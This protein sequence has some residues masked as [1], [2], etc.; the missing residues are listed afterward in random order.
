MRTI[1]SLKTSIIFLLCFI[2][3][4]SF[5]QNPFITTWEIQSNSLAIEVDPNLEYNYDVDWESDGI[6]DDIG[7]TEEISHEYAEPGIFSISIRGEFPRFNHSGDLLG[8]LISVDQWGDIKWNRFDRAFN[9]AENMQL[10]AT[11]SPDLSEVTNVRFMF[12]GCHVMNADLSD[13]DM[14]NIERIGYM[15]WRCFAFNGDVTTWNVG[16]ANNMENMFDGCHS[17]NQDISE[18]DVS[19]STTMYNMFQNCYSFDQELNDWDVSRVIDTRSM[20]QNCKVFNRDLPNWDVSKVDRSW[21]MFFG[22]SRFNG[23]ISQWD[24]SGMT[25]M[26][27]MFEGCSDF[28]GDL[29][30][31]DVSN[32]QRF[33]NMFSGCRVFTGDLSSWDVSSATHMSSM[34]N[35]CTLFNSDISGWDVSKVWWMDN[36]FYG[37]T[38]FNADIS[39]WNPIPKYASGMFIDAS[40]FNQNLGSW[41]FTD[42][43]DLRL[44]LQG[45]GLDCNNYASLLQN[46]T[47]NPN[48]P[49]DMLV[50]VDDLSYDFNGK[51]YRDSLIDRGWSFFGDRLASCDPTEQNFIST[52][53]TDTQGASCDSCIIITTRDD[54]VYNYDIDWNNDG[55]FDSIGVKGDVEHKFGSSGSFQIAIRGQFPAIYFNNEGDKEKIQSIDQW[56]AIEWESMNSAFHGCTN[57]SNEANDLPNLQSVTDLSYM[58][59]DAHS[60]NLDMGQWD[61]SQVT[62]MTA[63]LDTSGIDCKNYS[64]TLLG[65]ATNPLSPINITLGS[66]GLMYDFNSMVNRDSLLQKNWFITGDEASDCT[67]IPRPFVT[68]WQ[69]NNPGASCNSC[70]TIPTVDGVTYS[71]D[72]DWENDGIYDEFGVNRSIV[73]DYGTPGTYTVAI[74]GAFPQISFY[75]TAGSLASKDDLEKIININQWGDMQWESMDRAFLRCVN[76]KV[77]AT[78]I[79]DLSKV[80]SMVSMF[81]FCPEFDADVSQ[82]DVSNVLNLS[83]LFSRCFKFNSD[84]SLWDVSNVYNMGGLFGYCSEFDQNLDTWNVRGVDNMNGMFSKCENFNG[85]IDNWDVSN[86][87]AMELM[88]YGC[89]I[90]NRDIS[91]W[92]VSN[93]SNMRGLFLDCVNFNIDLKDWD[94]GSVGNM[95]NMFEGCENFNQALDQWDVSGVGGMREMFRGCKSFNSNL[96]SWDVSNVINMLE[97]FYDC[98]S[99]NGDISD[100]DV[101]KVR[102]FE[103][104]FRNCSLFNGELSAWDVSANFRPTNFMFAG[105]GDFNSNINNWDMSAVTAMEG[106][107]QGCSQFSSDLSSWDVSKANSMNRMFQDCI[108]FDSDLEEWNVSNVEDMAYMFQ[109]CK[110]FNGDVIGWDVS[111]VTDMDFM[112]DS[113]YLFNQDIGEWDVSAVSRMRWMFSNARSF[114]QNIGEWDVSMVY[115]MRFMFSNARSF[116]QDIGNWNLNSINYLF[117]FLDYSG[118]GCENYG[119]TLEGW[120]SSETTP[121]NII[122]GVRDVQYNASGEAYRDMLIEGGWTF[123]GDIK[124]DCTVSLFE[125]ELNFSIYPNPTSNVINIDSDINVNLIITDITG[126]RLIESINAN[127]IDLSEL[128]NGIYF[129]EIMSDFQNLI[130]IEKIIKI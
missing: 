66:A 39:S 12:S 9:G 101:G 102:Y 96:N 64:A 20:F 60:M 65:W 104:M 41:D 28:N 10:L 86:V 58:F 21:N 98:T 51:E 62:D 128:A 13:W 111:S 61:I 11:D 63:M 114:D 1:I 47:Q 75:G 57:L 54:L 40:S 44:F 77:D 90:F 89:S 88:F 48:L 92:D 72:V 99:F 31:W 38:N 122:V 91:D 52:W 3:Q 126:Q 78:D 67:Y 22:C 76:L 81:G 27:G 30:D 14:S 80:R 120:S 123:E 4:L 36:M 100:W 71:Y 109:N 107:F 17:F 117:E 49:N 6:Y 32:N 18:W 26:L 119:K 125:N 106:M 103:S 129:L 43:E 33:Y 94:V 95:S 19:R 25:S 121:N 7:V 24:V 127:R 55:I 85:N 37:A 16:R 82:W 130:S 113:C 73:H 42:I 124:S 23:D 50:G 110:K 5:S 118:L 97:M 83:G 2:C 115:D 53:R 74:R 45:S 87:K 8:R 34:F 56:G 116:D 70:I 112:F 105:C 59:F 84:L 69:T 15:F 29:S 68:T 46:W 93:V 79:P 108:E 35:N